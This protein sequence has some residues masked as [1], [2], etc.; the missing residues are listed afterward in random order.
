MSVSEE[1]QKELSLLDKEKKNFARRINY[2]IK[3]FRGLLDKV[4]KDEAS[5]KDI[6]KFKKDRDSNVQN[7]VKENIVDNTADLPTFSLTDTPVEEVVEEV[8]PDEIETEETE[9]RF[10]IAKDVMLEY[11]YFLEN[12]W[13]PSMFDVIKIGDVFRIKE[14]GRV[15]SFYGKKC[16]TP[17]SYQSRNDEG[18][19]VMKVSVTELP[20]SELD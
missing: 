14:D 11:D 2:K 7:E 6:A 9:S 5:D 18:Q 20:S 1:I 13:H 16:L 12:M 19:T 3:R 15:L 8:I 4:L 10:E 17:V